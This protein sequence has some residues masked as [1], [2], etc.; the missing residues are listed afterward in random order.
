MHPI[1]FEISEQYI[2]TLHGLD[3]QTLCVSMCEF[4]QHI[5]VHHH[6]SHLS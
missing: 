5:I 6:S 1:H 2:D 3:S 4:A